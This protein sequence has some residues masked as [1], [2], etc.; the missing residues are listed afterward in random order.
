M[1]TINQIVQQVKDLADAHHQIAEVGVGTI[2][3][4]QASERSYPLL[5]ISHEQGS[6]QDNYKINN[7][8]LTV[9]DR[10]LT[11]QEGQDDT[12]HEQEVL[13]DTETILLDFLN[14]FHQNHSQDY[15]TVKSANLEHFTERTNDRTA[16]WSTVLELRQFYDWN[17]CQIP[18]SGASIS[19]SVD[20]LTLYDFC[21][22]ATVA[23]LTSAQRTCLEAELCGV[24]DPATITINGASLGATGSVASGESLNIIVNLDGSPSGSWDGDSWEV[25]SSS[26]TVAIGVYSDAGYTTPITEA[27]FGDTIYIRATATGITPI[28]YVFFAIDSNDVL[29]EI[30]EG[31]SQ[32][33]SWQITSTEDVRLFALATEDNTGDI[34]YTGVSTS[35]TVNLDADAAAF[36]TAHE[37]ATGATMAQTQKDAVI[38]FVARLK[39]VG[40]TFGSDLFTKLSNAGSRLFP[41]IPTSDSVASAA[42]YAINI[43]NPAQ[44]GSFVNLLPSDITPNGVTGGATKYF[45]QGVA[46]SAFTSTDIGADAYSR[47]DAEN[48]F[49][50]FGSSSGTNQNSSNVSLFPKYTGLGALGRVNQSSSFVLVAVANSLGLVSVDR[51]GTTQTHSRNGVQVATNTSTAQTPSTLN[52]YGLGANGTTGLWGADTARQYA[53][54]AT[55]CTLN[56]NEMSDYYEAIQWLQTNVITGGRNV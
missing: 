3:E 20:G 9:F 41:F 16:G 15:I 50:A 35:F 24:P 1:L 49:L 45:D 11:G 8:R 43:I 55:R 26:S 27:S 23:R 54:F 36:I 2:A 4:L 44:T 32:D 13:S 33:T 53:L 21:D 19:P 47:T 10:V 22:A 38:G 51:S 40:T 34:D 29:Y 18:E 25:T 31:A 28:N 46:P 37:T 39:G 7:L 52:M 48:L 12:G 30:G 14:Y 17:K 5:W 42:G 6:L 56:T